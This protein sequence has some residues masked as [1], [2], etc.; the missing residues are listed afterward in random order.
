MEAKPAKKAA[1]AK[2][3]KAINRDVGAQSKGPRLQ[4]LRAAL[5]L[6]RKL[7]SYPDEVTY[8]AVEFQG[9]VFVCE[10]N[11]AR[12]SEYHEENKNYDA[13][14]SFTLNS[15]EVLNSIV[16]FLDCWISKQLSTAVFFGFYTPNGI[17]KERASLGSQAAAISWPE[18]PVLQTLSEQKAADDATLELFGS[19]VIDEYGRQVDLHTSEDGQ[20]PEPGQPLSNLEL[21]RGWKA[22]DWRAFLRQ[23]EWK[24]GES[25]CGAVEEEL[26]ST[27]QRSSHFDERLANKEGQI[28]NALVQLVDK[29]QE[30]ADPCQRFVHA[31]EVLLIFEQTASGSLRVPDPAW[32]LW[33]TLA[34]TDTRNLQEK[35]AAVCSTAST[36]QL[37]AWTRQAAQSLLEQAHFSDNRSVLALKYQIY[38][39]CEGKLTERAQSELKDDLNHAEVSE[40]MSEL[41]QEA[42]SRYEECVKQ[43]HYPIKSKAS[44]KSIVFDLFEGCFLHF[45]A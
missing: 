34:P 38:D 20:G 8:C 29:R 43:F 24:F 22:N 45:E 5:L 1:K 37:A 27:I 14:V 7:D 9:D 26:I 17:G 39:A 16:S 2:K 41:V 33:Q 10:A 28:I 11:D 19:R 30:I 4:R 31:S 42:E 21:L 3:A 15:H 32:Q 18:E 44:V 36:R 23:V 25:D 13:T 12:T 40:L 6:I 35:V